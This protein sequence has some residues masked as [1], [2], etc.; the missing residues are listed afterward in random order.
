M[1]CRGFAD[2]SRYQPGILAVASLT[3]YMM[4]Y[5]WPSSLGLAAEGDDKDDKV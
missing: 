5:T 1:I 4:P 3:D 2:A